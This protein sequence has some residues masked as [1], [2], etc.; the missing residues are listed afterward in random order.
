VRTAAQT[1]AVQARNY[2]FFLLFL[3]F[4]SFLPFLLFLAIRT[5]SL[6]DPRK[7]NGMLTGRQ[8]IIDR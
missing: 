8:R 5:T 6:P 4:L 3:L 1:A 7:V 2:F